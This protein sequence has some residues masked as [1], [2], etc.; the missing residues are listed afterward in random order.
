MPSSVPDF[1]C[2]T[3]VSIPEEG[4]Y[5]IF[6]GSAYSVLPRIAWGLIWSQLL[7]HHALMAMPKAERYIFVGDHQ[8]MPPVIQGRHKGNPVNQSVFSYL[9][10]RYPQLNTILD[11][12]RR[13]NREITAF[14]SSEYYGGRLKPIPEVRNRKLKTEA[15][16]DDPILRKIL[17]PENP[18]VFVHVDHE[19][20][21]QESPEEASLVA[22]IVVEL[23]SCCG[24]DPKDGL[25]VVAAHRRQNNL[26]REYIVRGVKKRKINKAIV[27]KL[28]SP[29]LRRRT[30]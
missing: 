21:T 15:L 16:P 29:D 30:F 9:I 7:L 17:D 13:M 2:E 26:I 8:Q 20:Y 24:I 11:E 3:F 1:G 14:P 28:I 22:Q 18:V 25:C 6:I 10:G 27:K 4:S 19:G 5:I 23:V 12:T